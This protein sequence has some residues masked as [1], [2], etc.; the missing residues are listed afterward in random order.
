MLRAQVQALKHHKNPVKKSGL[1]AQPIVA[2]ADA[3]AVRRPRGRHVDGRCAGAA[4]LQ[5]IADQVD[6]QLAH[7][8]RVGQHRGQGVVGD[9]GAAVL[10]PQAQLEQGVG[11]CGLQRHGLRGQGLAVDAGQAEQVTDQGLGALAAVHHELQ[12]LLRLGWQR[13]L[14]APHQQLTVAG[15]HAQ[16]LLQIMRGNVGK[17]LQILVRA[18][19]LGGFF[20]QRLVEQPLLRDVLH[21]AHH[22]AAVALADTIAVIAVTAVAA[23]R[24]HVHPHP[25]HRAVGPLVAVLSGHRLA[26][27]DGALPIDHHLCPVLWMR[28]L[29]PAKAQA[30]RAIHAGDALPGGVGE[31]AAPAGLGHKHAQR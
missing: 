24:R 13:G 20:S 15:D 2:Y 5:R 31:L 7:L 18:H 9:G 12:K 3:P 19:Q 4:E 22:A 27:G 11:Q 28:G 29:V 10:H 14:V 16:R 26:A 1:D 30:G 23:D 25:H 8:P 17:A 6:Q 21:R